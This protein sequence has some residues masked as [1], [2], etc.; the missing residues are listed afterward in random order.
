ML[1]LAFLATRNPLGLLHRAFRQNRSMGLG[2]LV[3]PGVQQSLRNPAAKFLGRR[4]DWNNPTEF[5]ANLPPFRFGDVFAKFGASLSSEARQWCSTNNAVKMER[6]AGV[7]HR[8][9]PPRNNNLC[10]VVAPQPSWHQR[11][12]ETPASGEAAEPRVRTRRTRRCARSLKITAARSP[13]SSS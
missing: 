8:A 4:V 7:A 10:R 6:S 2:G 3:H 5:S 1:V 13:N 11:A 12:H 9:G